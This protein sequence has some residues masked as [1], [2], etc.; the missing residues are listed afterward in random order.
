M[1]ERKHAD[2]MEEYRLRFAAQK[3]DI[4]VL[5]VGSVVEEK[6]K[7]MAEEVDLLCK[8]I[9]FNEVCQIDPTSDS[10]LTLSQPDQGHSEHVK[11]AL[12]ALIKNYRGG[13]ARFKALPF[14]D[15]EDML[16][17]CVGDL[18]EVSRRY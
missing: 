7:A 8:E 1:E 10:K 6:V 2:A 18:M 14:L 3:K 15:N 11:E 16:M 17:T 12:D 13:L 9:E 5:P 4:E